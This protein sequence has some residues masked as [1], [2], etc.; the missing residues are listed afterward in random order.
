MGQSNELRF[1]GC[2]D[3][4]SFEAKNALMACSMVKSPTV[5]GGCGSRRTWTISLRDLNLDPWALRGF[6]V[7]KSGSYGPTFMLHGPCL[8]PGGEL[9]ARG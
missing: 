4:R 8:I 1:V 5:L 2:I 7:V 6:E 9:R 3:G